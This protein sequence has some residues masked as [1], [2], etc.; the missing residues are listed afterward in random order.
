MGLSTAPATESI[1]G[2]VRPGPGRHRIS[3]Q[4]R[5]PPRR[6]HPRRRHP[7]SVYASLYRAKVATAPVPQAAREAAQ[8]SYG[9][10]RAAAAHL[11][12]AAGH[13]LPHPRQQRLPRRP[14]RR[15]RRRRRR[16]CPRSPLVAAYLPN[17]PAPRTL[18][19]RTR[20]PARQPAPPPPHPRSRS[21]RPVPDCRSRRRRMT[22]AR[23]RQP[24]PQRTAQRILPG[25]S[26][27]VSQAIT[28]SKPQLA[29]P[30]KSR[31][32]PGDRG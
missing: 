19:Q 13:N 20:T 30:R 10:S 18:A 28:M 5:P 22:T 17:H 8:A 25:D 23:Q 7:R 12:P 14:A 11:P 32:D 3:G 15:L 27:N 31:S 16:L 6:R 9:A 26:I 24:D 21:S 1:L 2:V 29:S 4:R